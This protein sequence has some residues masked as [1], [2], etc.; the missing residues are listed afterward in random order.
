MRLH[1][2][3]RCRRGPRR[4]RTA[5]PAPS[6]ARRP[7][8]RLSSRILLRRS[9]SARDMDSTRNTMP[10]ILPTSFQVRRV[11]FMS[12]ADNEAHSLRFCSDLPAPFSSLLWSR[13]AALTT[14]PAVPL[15]Y[16]RASSAPADP[17]AASSAP[18]ASSDSGAA[19]TL[20]HTLAGPLRVRLVWS[21]LL[22][23]APT[24]V[25]DLGQVCGGSVHGLPFA[26]ALH[27]TSATPLLVQQHHDKPEWHTVA[28]T[29][30]HTSCRVEWR[31]VQR[32]P[33]ARRHRGACSSLGGLGGPLYAAVQT[34]RARHGDDG[35]Q[36]V[37]LT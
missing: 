4:R 18:L 10:T 31:R 24:L 6:A 27:M 14:P 37:T 33:P 34:T 3:V 8:V 28:F 19:H 29:M 15:A 22:S 1:P 36:C 7:K 25:I 35:R 9:P 12:V 16:E 30:Y 13:A 26:S 5:P 2:A 20:A 11:W 32:V 21:L 23:S 17:F